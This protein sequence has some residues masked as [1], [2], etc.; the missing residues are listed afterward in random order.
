MI[1]H[2]KRSKHSIRQLY[3][4]RS[5]SRKNTP[6]DSRR[7]ALS[8]PVGTLALVV[9][10]QTALRIVA[11]ADIVGAVSAFEDVAEEHQDLNTGPLDLALRASLGTRYPGRIAV[12]SYRHMPKKNPAAVRLG[13]RGGKARGKK[14]SKRKRKEIARLGG[15][16]RWKKPMEMSETDNT[17]CSYY[18]SDCS[19]RPEREHVTYDPPRIVWLCAFHNQVV[20]RIRRI[21]ALRLKEQHLRGR[22]QNSNRELCYKLMLEYRFSPQ[23]LDNMHQLCEQLASRLG[24]K[25]SPPDWYERLKNRPAE[26]PGTIQVRR[27]PMPKGNPVTSWDWEITVVDTDKLSRALASAEKASGKC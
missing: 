24:L 22:L 9:L 1:G 10:L 20:N 12:S 27:V 23:F 14:P 13:R 17:A 16:A 25:P 15:L 2:K 5:C 3:G 18:G 21:L 4:F 7:S 11:D 19:G 26:K 8:R 6:T